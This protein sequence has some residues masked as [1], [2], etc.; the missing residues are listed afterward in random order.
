MR[1]LIVSALLSVALFGSLG[2]NYRTQNF[3]ISAPTPQ[4]AREIGDQAEVYRRDLAIEWIGRELPPWREPCPIEAQVAP[5]LG[6]GGATSFM[7]QNRQPFGWTMSIQGSRER[8]LD[9]V[10]P[11][12]ITH[13]IFATYFG[14]PLPRW[15]DE[16]ACTTVEHSS[17]RHK[18]E[19]L[20]V[21]FLTTN[22]GIAFNKMFAMKEYPPDILPLYSQG[23]ALARFMI[24][25][26]GKQKFVQYVGEGMERNNWTA[27]TRKYY[28]YDTLG[29]LQTTWLEWVQRGTPEPLPADLVRLDPN[30]APP[31]APAGELY[32]AANTNN[33]RP[34]PVAPVAVDSNPNPAAYG[35]GMNPTVAPPEAPSWAGSDDSISASRVESAEGWYQRV[36]DDVR[37]GGAPPTNAVNPAAP[38]GKNPFRGAS[39]TSTINPN[40]I[41]TA[42][43]T[44]NPAELANAAMSS[45]VLPP[46]TAMTPVS[47][48]S[49]SNNPFRS[50]SSDRQVLLEWR[51]SDAETTPE[52]EERRDWAKLDLPAANAV[53]QR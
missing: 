30:P 23:Y 7:F 41:P 48:L 46:S 29:E 5:H 3:L 47:S 27:A 33:G 37:S 10:L 53:L 44:A 12:E 11:H 15:A 35:M 43:S 40:G 52:A 34:A 8:V 38:L 45:A 42:P 26:G 31:S 24:H 32:V 21:E 18:Q 9:S 17:E 28:G 13:T 50:V 20:L 16:G 51:R 49:E 25:Q 6:A 4:L 14:R 39:A 2:A 1:R 22:R 19:R 36:R